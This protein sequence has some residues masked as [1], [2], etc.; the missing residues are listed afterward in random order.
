MSSISN[1]ATKVVAY[2]ETTNEGLIKAS[3]TL[4]RIGM[5]YN[6]IE[7]SHLDIAKTNNVWNIVKWDVDE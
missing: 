6:W 2:N 3:I 5:N 7:V 1:C 4:H